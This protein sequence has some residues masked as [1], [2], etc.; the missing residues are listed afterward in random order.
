LEV[1]YYF[2]DKAFLAR[3][4]ETLKARYE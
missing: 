2:F 3:M 4:L 1:R